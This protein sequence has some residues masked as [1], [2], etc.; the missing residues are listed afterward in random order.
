LLQL[1][2]ERG[3]I[4]VLERD[5]R[6]MVLAGAVDAGQELGEHLFLRHRVAAQLLDAELERQLEACEG[7]EATEHRRRRFEPGIAAGAEL[8]WL[9]PRVAEDILLREPA[10]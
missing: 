8:R 1:G 2:G 9:G 7:L 10:G 3:R 6:A 4:A 5:E